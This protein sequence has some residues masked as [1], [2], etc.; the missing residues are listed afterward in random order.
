MCLTY[1]KF[2][3]AEKDITCYKVYIK[4]SDGRIVSP[5][6][7][8]LVP[9]I[10]ILTKTELGEINPN[11]GIQKGFHSFSSFNDAIMESKDWEECPY[12]PLIAECTIPKNSKYYEG[13]FGKAVSYCSECI[14][15]NKLIYIN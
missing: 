9:K 4:Y 15:L 8:I 3:I 13:Y 11:G 12:L 1:A 14:K 10:G 7:R 5:Y 6:R 2:K